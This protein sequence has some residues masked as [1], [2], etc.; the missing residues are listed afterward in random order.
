MYFAVQDA[1]MDDI[2]IVSRAD[3]NTASISDVSNSSIGNERQSVIDDTVN[4]LNLENVFQ[5]DEEFFEPA[6]NA[7]FALPEDND[8]VF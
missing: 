6:E 8:Q 3:S 2:S 4:A 7:D 1:N 5:D